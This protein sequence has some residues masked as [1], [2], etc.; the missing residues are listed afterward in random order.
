V[1]P[2]RSSWPWISIASPSARPRYRSDNSC[3]HDH[4][5]FGLNRTTANMML[6]RN[7]FAA[8]APDDAAEIIDLDAA[9]PTTRLVIPGTSLC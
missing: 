9:A 3:K 4:R 2:A 6:L 5:Y 1:I 8:L 7:P